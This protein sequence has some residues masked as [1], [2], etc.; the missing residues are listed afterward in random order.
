MKNK[1][2]ILV[3]DDNKDMLETVN[4]TLKTLNYEVIGTN[5]PKEVLGIIENN[6]INILLSDIKMP[7]IT[8]LDLTKMIKKSFPEIIVILMTGFGDAYTAQDALMAGAD[9]YITKPFKKNEIELIVE[10]ASWRFFSIKL[11]KKL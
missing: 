6:E 10:R 5:D 7:E 1:I 9:E 11:R 2:R 8:G 4:D 3:V